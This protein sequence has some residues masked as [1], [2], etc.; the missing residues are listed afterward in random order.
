MRIK[1]II[2]DDN[3]KVLVD[4]GVDVTEDQIHDVAMYW[5]NHDP[6]IIAE[7]EDPF[8]KACV[9]ADYLIE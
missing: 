8:I 4:D 6:F 7:V 1:V 3:G 9:I 2:E 5:M